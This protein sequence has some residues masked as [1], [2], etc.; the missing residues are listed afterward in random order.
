MLHALKNVNV[1]HLLD[2]RYLDS[3]KDGGINK[4]RLTVV[5]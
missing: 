1:S 3:D 4:R 5:A 2:K